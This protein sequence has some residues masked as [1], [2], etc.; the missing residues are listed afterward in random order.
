M[1]ENQWCWSLINQSTILVFYRLTK[2]SHREGHEARRMRLETV[3]LAQP[4]A[5]GHRE[6]PARLTRR[7]AP[8]HHLFALADERQHRAHRLDAHAV[9][10]RTPL[11]QCEV[12]RIARGSLE[13]GIPQDNPP[14]FTLPQTPGNPRTPS[15]GPPSPPPARLLAHILCSGC[16]RHG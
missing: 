10:P 7:P 13:A 11:T 5:S 3:P 14:F 15:A 9:L 8:M 12:R 2:C 1:I 16:T 4:M 6:G